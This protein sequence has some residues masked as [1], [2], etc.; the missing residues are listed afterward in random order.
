MS[1]ITIKDHGH[2]ELVQ[3]YEEVHSIISIVEFKNSGLAFI[4]VDKKVGSFL[5]KNT[6]KIIINA[7]HIITIEP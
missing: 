3:T 5:G 6:A 4:E 7:S 2:I 1:N